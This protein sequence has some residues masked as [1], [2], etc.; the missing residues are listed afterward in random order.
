VYCPPVAALPEAP[1]RII[2][3]PLLWR[4]TSLRRTAKEIRSSGLWH[5]P[6]T[7]SPP[8]WSSSS[9]TTTTAIRPPAGSSIYSSHSRR[10]IQRI[11]TSSSAVTTTSPSRRSSG[12]CRRRPTAP[13]SRPPGTITSTFHDERRGSRTRAPCIV[14]QTTFESYGVADGCHGQS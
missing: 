2:R 5:S 1:I 4:S 3:N 8:R 10:A 11:A 13:C 7:L 12:R 14:A 9:L 6:P